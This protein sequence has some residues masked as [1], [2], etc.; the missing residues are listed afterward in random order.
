MNDPDEGNMTGEP[1]FLPAENQRSCSPIDDYLGAQPFPLSDFFETCAYKATDAIHNKSEE[2][3]PLE[4]PRAYSI[5]GPDDETTLGDAT[6]VSV[7]YTDY[8]NFIH[9]EP[10]ASEVSDGVDETDGFGGSDVS[11]E[12]AATLVNNEE[13][14]TEDTTSQA[15][16]IAVIDGCIVFT[17]KLGVEQRIPIER[18]SWLL[19]LYDAL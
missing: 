2:R 10:N 18:V 14:M 15:S 17:N 12:S 1:G 11:L 5:E 7:E 19:L 4:Y 8:T 6:T 9:N 16:S 3:Y 13:V